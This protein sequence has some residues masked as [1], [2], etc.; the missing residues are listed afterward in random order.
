MYFN[1]KFSVFSRSGTLSNPD[2]TVKNF[3][4][5]AQKSNIDDALNCLNINDKDK[6]YIKYFEKKKNKIK[7]KFDI[8][9]VSSSS[10]EGTVKVTYK[11]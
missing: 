1:Y 10:N 8:K 9:N 6:E 5:I 4:K 7:G 3:I 11:K 2:E